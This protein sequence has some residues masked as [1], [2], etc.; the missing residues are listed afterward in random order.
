MGPLA[1]LTKLALHML[2][3][4]DLVLTITRGLSHDVTT[5][6]DLKLW[7]VAKTIHHDA[8]SCEHFHNNNVDALAEDCLNER[9]P[10]SAWDAVKQFMAE[11][12]VRGLCKID[13]G[14]PRWRE[15]PAPLV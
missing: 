8:K 3:G 11:H 4:K 9:L 5:K 6:M 10:G 12:G 14:R 2:D 1:L 13:L 15:E 7:Q